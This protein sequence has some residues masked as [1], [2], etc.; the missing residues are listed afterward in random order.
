LKIEKNRKKIGRKKIKREE[1]KEKKRNH[2]LVRMM[3]YFKTIKP[4]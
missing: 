2:N 4:S 1:E 3:G